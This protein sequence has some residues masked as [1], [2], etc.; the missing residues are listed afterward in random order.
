MLVVVDVVPRVPVVAV[1]VVQ[2]VVVGHRA[3]PTA[4][5]VDVHVARVRQVADRR[6]RAAPELVHVVLVDVV[7]VA[8]VQEVDVVLVGDCGVPAEPVVDVLVLPDGV[9]GVGVGHQVLRH[10]GSPNTP[11]PQT[12]ALP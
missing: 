4:R 5:L 8:V 9:V 12:T 6:F 7:D 3:V 1:D 11:G 10:H 2:V